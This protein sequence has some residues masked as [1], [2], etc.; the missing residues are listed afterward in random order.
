MLWLMDLISFICFG[1]PFSLRTDG[2]VTEA[3]LADRLVEPVAIVD[4]P[5]LEDEPAPANG[6][7]LVVDDYW[8]EDAAADT[9]PAAPPFAAPS[10]AGPSHKLSRRMASTSS[11]AINVDRLGEDYAQYEYVVPSPDVAR[12]H[13]R[14]ATFSRGE[15]SPYSTPISEFG[16]MSEGV[17]LYFYVLKALLWLFL[18]LSLMAI[19]SLVLNWE[20]NGGFGLAEDKRIEV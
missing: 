11:T 15:L 1:L 4:S 2:P 6:S 8:E 19:P 17:Q 10:F 14:A 20:G 18:F 9:T 16:N 12:E 7:S 5:A 13:M 3:A